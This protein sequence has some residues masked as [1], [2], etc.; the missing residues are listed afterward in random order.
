MPGTDQ[1][2]AVVGADVTGVC[3]S[4]NVPFVESLG[5]HRVVDYT[6][7]DFTRSG[8]R[9]DLVLDVASNLT[10]SKRRR[11]IVPGG[12]YVLIGHDHFGDARGGLLGTLP[13]G[14]LLFDELDNVVYANPSANDL[15]GGAPA[16]LSGL[17]PFAFQSAVRECRE[18]RSPRAVVAEHRKPVRLLR[19][20]GERAARRY[21]LSAEV[22][23]AEEALRIGMLSVLVPAAELD[24]TIDGLLQH[25]LAG[26]PQA[27]AKIKDLIRAVAGRPLDD[28]LRT[29]TAKRIAEIRVSPEGKEGIAS[30][31]AKRK[32]SW[33]SPES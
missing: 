27:H 11:L 8:R 29:E 24:P 10:L 28:A 23:D 13:Q 22:F 7:E 3:G 18:Q 21:F 26:G 30:F 17:V 31:L 16:T 4:G 2:A 33:C 1:L 25:L 20:I 32:A 19:A 14:T 5:A 15:L 9:Y 12:V 6:R